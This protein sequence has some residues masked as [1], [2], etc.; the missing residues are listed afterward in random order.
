MTD[1]DPQN[2]L[3]STWNCACNSYNLPNSVIETSLYIDSALLPT[4][5]RPKPQRPSTVYT[6]DGGCDPQFAQWECP[7]YAYDQCEH[8]YQ[9]TGF[10]EDYI[11][12]LDDRFTACRRGAGCD[13]Q[14]NLDAKDCDPTKSRPLSDL[15]REACQR[16]DQE[17]SSAD[18]YQ[19]CVD[20]VT[21]WA[22]DGCT[23]MEPGRFGTPQNLGAGAQAMAYRDNRYQYL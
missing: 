3:N 7:V 16:P 11:Q 13:Y 4:I 14:F 15:V 12:C 23:N 1:V 6:T 18:A 17:Y 8:L 5:D 21:R 10:A 22:N 19:A 9:P 2:T 20:R